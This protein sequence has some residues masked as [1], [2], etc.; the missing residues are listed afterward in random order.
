[1]DIYLIPELCVVTGLTD[2]MRND[3]HLMKEIAEVT[4]PSGGTRIRY[5]FENFRVF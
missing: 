2:D 4:K 5:N 1:M 3:F